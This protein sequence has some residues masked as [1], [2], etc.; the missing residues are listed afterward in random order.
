MNTVVT[1]PTTVVGAH[2]ARTP[3]EESFFY[4]LGA[5]RT[6][7]GGQTNP[8]FCRK[9][10]E[11]VATRDWTHTLL[12]RRGALPPSPATHHFGGWWWAPTHQAGG[13]L[14]GRGGGVHA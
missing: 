9:P 3:S 1:A 8:T 13:W 10:Q 2:H 5:L 11:G 6:S 14:G 4:F 7:V 12:E